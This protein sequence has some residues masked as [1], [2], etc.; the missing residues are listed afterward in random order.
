V[1]EHAWRVENE[2]GGEVTDTDKYN[3]AFL[4]HVKSAR[5]LTQAYHSGRGIKEACAVYEA[6]RKAVN[7]ARAVMDERL[8][9]EMETAN[10]EWKTK[11]VE[12]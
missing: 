6:A 2:R 3:A 11:G 8:N 5:K 10:A 12:K 9:S 1:S 7:E 4:A